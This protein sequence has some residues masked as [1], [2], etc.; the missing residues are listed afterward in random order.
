M[1]GFGLE[2]K[3]AIV[4]GGANGIG[5]ATVKLLLEHQ[6]NVMVADRC[7][8]ESNQAFFDDTPACFMKADMTDEDH[9]RELMAYTIER[10]GQIDVLVN[11]A[12]G[13]AVD[14]GF[15]GLSKASLD[16]EIHQNLLTA[17]LAVKHVAATMTKQKAGSII[18]VA[19]VAA[20]HAAMGSLAYSSAKAG[21][22]Q[23]TRTAA[24]RLA[25]YNVRANCI[26]PGIIPT[27]FLGRTYGLEGKQAERTTRKLRR[28]AKGL[29]PLPV[30]AK[31]S[32]IA[33][34]IC[35]F[36]GEG[37]RFVTGQSLVVDGGL[38][39]GE[40]PDLDGDAFSQLLAYFDRGDR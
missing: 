1:V 3:V 17:A 38:M 23:L 10:F 34:A 37:A 22:V 19:S 27:G 15:S 8:D 18:N 21:L 25:R 2:G 40:G 28:I 7:I 29:Q 33:Q 11:S 26:L 16:K 5:L 9:V 35:F 24:A 14:R 4:T 39:V 6:A 20:E 31:P 13:A 32:D 36:A 30:A 12:G